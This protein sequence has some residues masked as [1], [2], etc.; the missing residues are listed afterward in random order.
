ML[1]AHS[2]VGFLSSGFIGVDVF[3]VISGY[4][5]TGLLLRE[6]SANGRIHLLPFYVR[7][8]RRIIPAAL[9]VIVV[10]VVAER[11][12]VGSV[13]ASDATGYGRLAALFVANLPT[14]FHVTDHGSFGSPFGAYWSLSVEEQ[15]YLVYPV[16][17]LVTLALVPLGT[18]RLRLGLLLGIAAMASF[19]YCVALSP[20]IGFLYT[21]TSPLTRAWELAVGG[22][23]AV[24]GT[25]TTSIPPRLA[26]ALSWIGLVAILAAAHF[27]S[28]GP[29]G[30]PGYIAAW[31]VLAAAML[32]AGGSCAPPLGAEWLLKRWPFRWLGRWSYSLYL[33]HYPILVVAAQRWGPLSARWNLPLMVLAVAM[34]AG[35]YFGI[36]NPIR[37]S[38]YLNRNAWAGIALGVL[39]VAACLAVLGAFQ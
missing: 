18:A 21:Y 30:Y 22:L 4:V 16:L 17:A 5:I 34:S 36:E 25:R 26:A 24:V 2:G 7:R 28:S 1:L 20:G 3:F 6:C 9:F 14:Y 8:V 35:T 11:L 39:L 32:I 37:H 23:V 13:A 15:F 38:S 31:P 12:L 10:T 19:S 27:L 33:W 29:G